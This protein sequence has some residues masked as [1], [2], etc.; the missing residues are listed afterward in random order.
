MSFTT[1]EY[2]IQAHEPTA[3]MNC[4][5]LKKAWER[6][7]DDADS[8]P[9]RMHL[10]TFSITSTIFIKTLFNRDLNRGRLVYMF[11]LRFSKSKFFEATCQSFPRIS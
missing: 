10:Q 11:S 7:A 8:I 9:K 2:Y 3:I 4:Y 1:V 5:I 6:F